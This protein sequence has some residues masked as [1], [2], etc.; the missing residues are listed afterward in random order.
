[1][2]RF[3]ASR[4][5]DADA[6]LEVFP[7][8]RSRKRQMGDPTVR[9]NIRLLCLGLLILATTGC[10]STRWNFLKRDPANDVAA[11]P[12]ATP[13]VVNLVG[14]LN[15]NSRRVQSVRFDDLSVD[16]TQ[17]AGSFNS[18][19]FSLP[20]TLFAEKPRNFR[21]KASVLG[22]DEADIGSNAQEF[23]FWIA[24]N[25]EPRQYFCTYRDLDEGRVQ[26]MPLPIQPEWVM[27]TL[28]LA[29]YGPPDKYQLELD[30]DG[31]TLRLIEKARSPSGQPVRKVIVMQRKEVVAPQPQVTAYLLL[32][33][34]TGQEICSAHITSVKV[35]N[36]VVLPN[37]LELR[38]PAQKMKMAMK[39]DRVTVN[40]ALPGTAFIRPQMSGIEPF[41]L[42]TGRVEGV[43]RTQGTQR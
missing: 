26:M 21:L 16:V 19:T 36:G 37:K 5:L 1:M 18:Q 8:A 40:S 3:A 42:A 12:G 11:K 9:S 4:S 10:E 14:Y 25:P 35:V 27:E 17:N 6:Y 32:D 43:Q 2:K 30:K 23:W 28:G 39:I 20:G 31:K 29:N 15:E 7:R 13:T 33:D 38:M 34:A 24:R 41:N 22:K